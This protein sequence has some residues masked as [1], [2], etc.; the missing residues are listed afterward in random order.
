[1]GKEISQAQITKTGRR[2]SYIE[3]LVS[4]CRSPDG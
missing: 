2:Q 4:F 3:G 1:M